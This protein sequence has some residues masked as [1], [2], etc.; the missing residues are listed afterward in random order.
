MSSENDE[1]IHLWISDE[2]VDRIENKPQGRDKPRD[3]IPAEHGSK[4]SA[5][6]SSIVDFYNNT[7]KENSLSDEDIM[8][9]KVI[10]PEGEKI[11]N[12]QRQKLLEGEG[13]TINAVKDSRQVIVSTKKQMFS[14][15]SN[16]VNTYKNS[17]KYGGFQYVDVFEPYTSGDKQ[18]GDLIRTIY[19][20]EKPPEIIDVQMLLIPKLDK[21][22][23]SRTVTKL[24][25]KIKDLNGNVAEEPYYLTDGTPVIR[26]IIPSE[27]LKGLAEDDAIYRVEETRFYEPFT[28]ST[29][30]PINGKI[31]LDQ[32][33]DIDSLP[34]VA[35][36]DSGINFPDP[37]ERLIV[38]HWLPDKSSGGDLDHGSKVASKVIF[39]NIGK[40]LN[41]GTFTP[42]AR[43]IDCNVMDGRVSEGVLIKRIQ[44]AVANYKDI[45][46]IYNLSANSDKPIEG[47]EIS[48][49]GYELDNL[50]YENGVQFIISSGNHY[51]WRT[52]T[53][54]EEILD[55]DDSRISAPADAMLGITV[56]S[57]IGSDN[58]NS[59]SSKNMIAP[60]SRKGPGFGG[61]RKPDIMA[62]G[63][64]VFIDAVN[65]KD[66][67]VPPDEYSLLINS[68]GQIVLDAGTSFTAPVVSGD[69]A[70]VSQIIPGGDILLSKA[71]LYHSSIPLWD[72][73]EIDNDEAEY[74]A[75]LYGRG[76]SVPRI[77]KYSAPHRVTFVRTGELNRKTK[78]HVKFFMPSVLAALP[79]RNSAKVTVTCVTSPPIDRTKGTQYLG[80][81]ILTSLHKVGNDG[82]MPTVNPSIK[83]GRRKWDTCYHFENTF[84]KFN[85]GDWEV[86]LELFTRWEVGDTL[87]IPYAIAITIEDLSKTLDIYN[88]IQLE[89]S[90]RYQP[91]STV[92]IP[93]TI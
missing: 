2:Q 24:S 7:A 19:N 47:Y 36:L 14:R 67:I 85:A 90:G 57:I 45:A 21:G 49:I 3:V 53:T 82:K 83:E 22:V 77:S 26:A 37:L 71:L 35:V 33:V 30:N 65:H 8:V 17:G 5:G 89:A 29:L 23:Y 69:L 61:F 75:N 73:E 80:A 76:L 28:A 70:E 10:L 15:L 88:A 86:W 11:D 43:V 46:K 56:G 93:V 66:M 87:N 32:S 20:S 91:M 51:I 4:L 59:L 62:Y 13:L 50:M 39:S 16:R 12:S 1:R 27:I 92:R 72:E 44:Q 38:T 60:Y 54:L 79:G 81:Y 78:E 63:A 18:S 9:F 84:S 42:R 55:D 41:E 52:S 6:L 25:N 58:E 48:I 74:I 68:S 34:V 40:Q 31:S 64:N